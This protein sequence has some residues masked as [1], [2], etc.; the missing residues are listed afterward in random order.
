[1]S[2]I[3]ALS[4]IMMGMWGTGPSKTT[5]M[6]TI[7]ARSFITMGSWPGSESARVDNFVEEVSS[8][9]VFRDEDGVEILIVVL[10]V[11]VDDAGVVK[12]VVVMGSEVESVVDEVDV[13]AGV[14]EVDVE[15]V[16]VDVVNVVDAGVVIGVVFSVE[17]KSLGELWISF[18][19]SWGGKSV[20]TVLSLSVS[21]S[22]IF[23]SKSA[24]I[25]ISGKLSYSSLE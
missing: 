7:L 6:S 10:V 9:I 18:K 1:M 11:V 17:K 2:L 16:V 19:N 5:G 24:G 4:F 12:G 22:G 13:E 14:V 15:D 20:M 21:T 3:C 25:S 23:L 8:S